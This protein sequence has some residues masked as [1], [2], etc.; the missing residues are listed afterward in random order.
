MGI[1]QS[2][3]GFGVTILVPEENVSVTRVENFSP[4]KVGGSGVLQHMAVEE[5]LWDV[6]EDYRISLS[7]VCMEGYAHQAR[8]GRERA[9]E[10]GGLVKKVLYMTLF[11]P[12]ARYPT[13]VAIP[14]L[15]QFTTGSGKATKAQ[16]KKAVEVNWG[17][18]FKDDNAADSYALAK[19]A[20]ALDTGVT[21][22]P[23]QEKLLRVLKRHTEMTKLTETLA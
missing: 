11:D 18:K 23:L 12:V 6:V 21:A 7:H 19:I 5:W 16:M 17:E 3:S 1:D 13:V 4:A 10:L 9:G 20:E 8:F 22:N 14:H 2:Y 15:K